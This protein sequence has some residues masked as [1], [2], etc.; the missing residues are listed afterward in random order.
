MSADAPIL[1]ATEDASDAKLI[2]DMLNVEFANV[3]FSTDPNKAVSDFDQC[4]PKVLI[5][6][7]NSLDKAQTYY[8]GLYRQSTAI[9]SSSFRTVILCT[10]DELRQVYELC[11]KEQFDDYV[12]FWPITYDSPR[13][14]MEVH[15][16]LRQLDNGLVDLTMEKAFAAQTRRIAGLEALLGKSLANGGERI[17]LVS[18]S[19]HQAEQGIGAA[20]EGFSR[21]LGSGE[22]AALDEQQ[23]R[24]DLQRELS[25]LKEES[26]DKLLHS[27]TAALEPVRRWASSLEEDFAPRL[28]AACAQGALTENIR[29]TILIID[30]DSFQHRLLAMAFA[31]ADLQLQFAISVP[32]AFAILQKQ[33]V[34][35]VLM[36]INMPG[37]S[38]I[39][40]TRRIKSEDRFSDIPVVM[41]TGDSHK[42]QVVESLK[43]GA[44]DFVVKPFDKEALQ[45]KVYKLLK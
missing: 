13:L 30:D 32:E 17:S 40:A 35:L 16:A 14:L 43:A 3:M 4:K 25:R 34:D 44:A 9:H 27:A 39:E 33:R 1:V 41:V 22:H 31:E 7:F 29:P 45:E 18:R 38:G 37:I 28:G 2:K 24:E 19:L 23:T 11:K 42:E 10:K 26:I 12:L 8:L 15:H 21:R 36:D 20:L 5:L 6:G